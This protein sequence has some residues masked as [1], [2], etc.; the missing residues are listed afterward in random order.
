[1]IS[2]S[3][4]IRLVK[5]NRCIYLIKVGHES[6]GSGVTKLTNVLKHSITD[7]LAGLLFTKLFY[8]CP[9]DTA[10]DVIRSRHELY[11]RYIIIFILSHN[12]VKLLS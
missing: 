2:Q 6:T 8:Y 5:S 11:K 12:K 7:D 4:N 1:M 9:I 3:K 10:T